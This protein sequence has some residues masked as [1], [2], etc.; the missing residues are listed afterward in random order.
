MDREAL[1]LQSVIEQQ[2]ARISAQEETIEGL[3]QKVTLLLEQIHLLKRGLFGRKSER[4]DPDQLALFLEAGET[5]AEVTESRPRSETPARKKG[6]GREA[7][8]E[9]LPRETVI[10][11]VGDDKRRCPCCGG[12]MTPIGEDVIERGHF[13]PSRVVVRR[14]VQK[15]Y[16]CPKGHGVVSGIVP[17]ALVPKAKYEPSVYAH[18]VA[19]KYC[20]HLPLHRLE[21]IFKRQGLRISKQTQWEMILRAYE[22]AARPILEQMRREVLASTVLL[23][24]ET[25]VTVRVE[26]VKGSR[27]GYV[28]AWSTLDRKTVFD[29]TLTKERDGPIRF[30]LDWIGSLIL[31]GSSSYDEVVRTNGIIRG[32]CW[33]HAR[34]KLT[35]A[36]EVG[37]QNA[38]AVLVFV[39]RLFAIERALRGRAERQGLSEK[40]RLELVADV[41]D[42]RSRVVVRKIYEAV[43]VLL[44]KRGVI[45]GGALGKAVTYLI[46]QRERLE[47]CLSDPRLPI[48]NN[49][50]ERA[51][52]H[53]VTGR[54]NWMIFASPRGGVVACA[55][56]S[57]MLSCK[58]MDIDPEAYLTDVLQRVATTPMSN[59][60]SLTPWA[61]A[62]GRQVEHDAPLVAALSF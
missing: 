30:L 16:A 62:R 4:L 22:L 58:A 35:D 49:D 54:N 10:C 15:K 3:E 6:H 13:V 8:S 25:P 52:R 29:F 1:L 50:S 56:Y 18:L 60:A 36:L 31:D 20:D 5:Q 19:A 27:K 43:D 33:A 32:G 53:V 55:L 12:E 2:R 47:V 46:N 23:A 45:P 21:G 28:W 17:Q 7:F 59:I 44:C 39:Q 14:Y 51:L 48:H 24:D 40:A 57:L 11:D 26:G 61:W 38:I 34:R 41:R 42:R 9:S 37:S